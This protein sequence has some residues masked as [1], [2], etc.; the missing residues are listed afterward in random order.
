VGS[1]YSD[2]CHADPRPSSR[3]RKVAPID[4]PF[5]FIRGERLRLCPEVVNDALGSPIDIVLR[6][7]R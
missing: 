5:D 7:Q 2:D 1:L 4:Q 3:C 6:P